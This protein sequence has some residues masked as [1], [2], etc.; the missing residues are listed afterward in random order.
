MFVTSWYRPEAKSARQ[1]AVGLA[2]DGNAPHRLLVSVSGV[3]NPG[4]RDLNLW[5]LRI[6]RVGTLRGGHGSLD[7]FGSRWKW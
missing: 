3:Q 1:G 2:F 6:Q 5:H 4:L 7:Q